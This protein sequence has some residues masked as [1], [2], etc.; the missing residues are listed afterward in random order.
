MRKTISFFSYLFHPIVIPTLAILLYFK[1]A[2]IFFQP[3]EI[4]ITI[5][6]VILTTF[7][8][9]I[10][11]Y[12]LL[13]SIHA[14]KSS[15]MVL[16]QKER[17]LPFLIQIALLFLLKHYILQ[18]NNVYEFNMF[19]WGLM[20]TYIGLTLGLL[21]RK[22]ISVHV[23]NLTALLSFYIL[24]SLHFYEAHLLGVSL[25]ILALGITATSRL[26]LQAHTTSEIVLGF[27]VGLIPQLTLWLWITL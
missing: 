4:S 23:A 18:A 2:H 5:S 11:L 7:L 17:M 16:N 19:I 21:I 20:Y 6:Q 10:A 24:F 25:L 9:P 8:I 22:K 12:F 26:L 1:D 15:I 3:L 14:L 27:L 13:H